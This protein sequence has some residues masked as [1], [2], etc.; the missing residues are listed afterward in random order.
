MAG[1]EWTINELTI[2]EEEYGNG[3]SAESLRKRLPNRTLGAIHTKASLLDLKSTYKSNRQYTY[4]KSFW[5]EFNPENCYWAG[6]TAADGCIMKI[7][8]SNLFKIEI[9]EK[10][11][12]EKFRKI[13]ESDYPISHIAWK[14]LH[15]IAYSVENDWTESLK[16]NFNII[17]RKTYCLEFPQKIP[18]ELVPYWLVGFID[19]DGCFHKSKFDLFSLSF[20]SASP[21]ILYSI[22]EWIDKY[23]QPWRNKSRKVRISRQDKQYP[24]YHLSIGGITACNLYLDL[25]KYIPETHLSRK[26]DRP[27]YVEF[28][29]NYAQKFP[30]EKNKFISQN[31]FPTQAP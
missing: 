11:H 3:K 9:K 12:L 20:V 30:V 18:D 19:G 14:N 28:C 31:N 22:N 5:N 4:N 7:G 8:N 25:R 29:K 17:P 27:E 16:A 24:H 10:Y 1:Q 6:F 2:L 23:Y 21:H 13:T 15:S 26:W